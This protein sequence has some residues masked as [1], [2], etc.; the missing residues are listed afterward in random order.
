MT[1]RGCRGT[2]TP[3]EA[4]PTVVVCREGARA[5]SFYCAS[6]LLGIDERD[7]AAAMT[8]RSVVA[9][10][11]TYKVRARTHCAGSRVLTRVAQ[12]PLSAEQAG[13]SRDALARSLY[14][15]A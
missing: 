9:G 7:V 4:A 12:V 6:E 15:L 8:F 10:G 3:S 13:H 1:W 2:A 14:V 11:E 5:H